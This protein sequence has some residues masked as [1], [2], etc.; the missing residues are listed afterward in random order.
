MNK[1]AWF[2][3]AVL[4]AINLLNFF[5]RQLAGALGEPV[6]IEFG[7]NDTALGVLG[8]IFTIIYALAGVPVGRLTDRWL[9]TRLIGIGV[10]V[11]SLFTGATGIAWN[12]WSLFV[13]RIGVGIGEAVCAPACQ[14]L[15]GD[16]FPPEKR[17]RALG[18]F[19]LGLPVGLSL[20]FFLGGLIG[21]AYGWRAAFL[22]ALVPGLILAVLVLFIPEP[23]RGA[24][25][26]QRAPVLAAQSSWFRSAVAVLSVPTLW[27][28]IASGAL[29]NFN[30]YAVMIFQTPFLQRFHGL[31]LY[32][33]NV[34]SALVV[35][36][37]GGIGLL[38]GGWLSDRLA[39]RRVDGR[40]LLSAVAMLAG[41]PC[42]FFAIAQPSGSIAPFI[43]LM[44]IGIATMH[45][46]YPTVYAAIQDVV[47][48]RMR[49]TA[50]ALYF[51]AMY[52]LGGSLGPIATGMLSDHFARR[53]MHAAGSDV[54]TEPFR[55]A[56]LHDAMFVVPLLM[57]LCAVVL[58][59][60]SRTVAE[61]VRRRSLVP[62]QTSATT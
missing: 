2:A 18:I 58:F 42:V 12:Y 8:S 46:Y 51:M 17:A 38:L 59:A 26:P 41:A 27:W 23:A 29:H 49:G 35:G 53:A 13:T 57:S 33:A 30:M 11:W 16:L 15:I 10:A 47:E 60:G 31:G 21:E 28:I 50:V 3:L 1:R 25:E 54:M 56:G 24:M 48:P 61:D 39:R 9:R 14:S 44:S 52:L 45:A 43:V 4:F 40:L 32:D 19:M 36:V 5:D 62:I 7:L 37:V 34:I 22:I 6:R 55:A 20:A